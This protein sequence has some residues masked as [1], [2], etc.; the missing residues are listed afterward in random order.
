MTPP[1]EMVQVWDAALYEENA[2]FISELGLE[3]LPLIEATHG[4]RI[5]D[6]GCGDGYVTERIAQFGADVLG[7][8]LSDSM[9]RGARA[10][11]LTVQRADILDLPFADEFDAVFSNSVLH[12]VRQPDKAVAGIARALKPGGRF[13]ADLSGAGSL[14]AIQTALH[15][16][17]LLHGGDVVLAHP[18]YQPTAAEYRSLLEDHGFQVD[19]CEHVA[20]RTPLKTGVEGWLWTFRAAFFEQFDES[21]REKV[22]EDVIEML[23]PVL[24]DQSGEWVADHMRLRVVAHHRGQ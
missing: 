1:A 4:Q 19:K 6:L 15:G 23:R 13:V 11:G 3:I 10:R 24:C 8:D 7:V 22:L 12:W 9:L 2:R 17:A 14:A 16:A 18:F 20:R 21:A 5:L